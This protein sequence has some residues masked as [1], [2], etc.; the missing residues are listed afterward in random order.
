MLKQPVHA[1]TLY[2]ERIGYRRCVRNKDFS[3]QNWNRHSY[4]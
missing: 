3:D 2:F 1:V 4:G